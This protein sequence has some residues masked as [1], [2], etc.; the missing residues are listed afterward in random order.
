MTICESCKGSGWNKP[1]TGACPICG[2]SGTKAQD[3]M[4]LFCGYVAVFVPVI[5]IEIIALLKIAQFLGVF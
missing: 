3:R 2:G 4:S 5:G 1:A